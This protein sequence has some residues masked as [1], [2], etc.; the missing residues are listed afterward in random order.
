MKENTLWPP[1]EIDL[2]TTKPEVLWL[3]NGT[4]AIRLD[5]LRKLLPTTE[6][7]LFYAKAAKL[8]HKELSDLLYGLFNTTVLS[9]LLG[10]SG[11]HSTELQ[12]YIV[13]TVP[14]HVL[15]A[16]RMQ[17]MQFV[18]GGKPEFLPELWDWANI[19]IAKSIGDVVKALDGTLTAIDAHTGRMTFATLAKLS[20]QRQSVIGTYEAM[21][22]HAATPKVLVI[23]DV[24]GSM[25]ET[26][27]SAV[28]NDVVGLAY[29]ANA[30][31]AIVSNTATRWNPGD[32]T[33]EHVLKLAEYDGTHYETLAPLFKEDWDVV[34]T[35][36]DYDSSWDAKD[37]IA[38]QPGRV[39]KVL[40][41][42]LVNQPTFLSECVGTLAD[43]VSPLIMGRGRYPIG[44]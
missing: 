26:T 43:E 2:R 3:K 33:A 30:T 40:D 38:Q 37:V 18:D 13:D 41:I 42:S 39:G 9:V 24:S 32:A 22:T 17:G 20:R 8:N 23:F 15:S 6:V 35:I 7:A 44:S 28:V 36:A 11:S 10:E 19:E 4:K 16:A 29:H 34:V 1:E 27:V 5:I 31:L 25:S 12:S 14:D 21:I